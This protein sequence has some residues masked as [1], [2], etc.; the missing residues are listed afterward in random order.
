MPNLSAR[1][2]T[3]GHAARPPM[4]AAWKGFAGS[5]RCAFALLQQ[6]RGVYHTHHLLMRGLLAAPV[7]LRRPYKSSRTLQLLRPLT[8][9]CLK[10][11]LT[12][13]FGNTSS[14]LARRVGPVIQHWFRQRVILKKAAELSPGVAFPL[15]T[16]VYPFECQSADALVILAYP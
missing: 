4:L 2:R 14:I 5:A 13:L 11:S 15:A 9:P 16:P 10:F 1:C 12:R 8:E 3:V 6:K 7:R